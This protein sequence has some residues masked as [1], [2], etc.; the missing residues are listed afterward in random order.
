MNKWVIQRKLFLKK[1]IYIQKILSLILRIFFT[2]N[3]CFYNLHTYIQ[4]L[5]VI[6]QVEYSWQISKQMYLPC[7]QLVLKNESALIKFRNFIEPQPSTAISYALRIV[8]IRRSFRVISGGHPECRYQI[9]YIPKGGYCVFYNST[10]IETKKMHRSK[11]WI[12]NEIPLLK[13][14]HH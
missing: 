5:P 14:R 3:C 8:W 2:S 9:E 7:L 12:I 4:F 6:Y 11:K 13:G 10:C 1:Y